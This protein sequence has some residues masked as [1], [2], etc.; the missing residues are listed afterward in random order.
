MAVGGARMKGMPE[1][2]PVLVARRTAACA[3]ASVFAVPPAPLPLHAALEPEPVPELPER[4]EMIPVDEETRRRGPLAALLAGTAGS[5]ARM[6]GMP[7]L[8]AGAVAVGAALL[9]LSPAVAAVALFMG[10]FDP[11]PVEAKAITVP[12]ALLAGGLE[13][14]PRPARVPE[15]R[16]DGPGLLRPRLEAAVARGPEA[17]TARRSAYYTQA[18]LPAVDRPEPA[19]ADLNPG[20]LRGLSAS[21]RRIEP[22][23]RPRLAPRNGGSSGIGALGGFPAMRATVS[24]RPAGAQARQQSPESRPR[25]PSLGPLGR[26]AEIPEV[27]R[28]RAVS[29]GSAE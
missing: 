29:P 13:S 28:G 23:E 21:G 9:V 26:L 12:E 1:I 3:A 10:A 11:A 18:S 27:G 5:I 24:R 2:R 7:L 16:A 25:R 22:V 6:T 14:G 15:R 17:A 20:G 8:L 4:P 19:P